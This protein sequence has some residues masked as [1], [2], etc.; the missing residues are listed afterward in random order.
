MTDQPISKKK[1]D[2][3]LSRMQD[4]GISEMDIVE[5]FEIGGGKGG[6]KVNKTASRVRLSYA[7]KQITVV[8]QKTRSREQ[9]RF[10]A[11]R[12]LCDRLEQLALGDVGAVDPKIEKKIKQKKRRKR[13][14]SSSNQND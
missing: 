3:L 1:E 11:R 4:L 2:E 13:R 14:S 6:Q 9:N 10:F 7:P 12:L 8:S 5:R